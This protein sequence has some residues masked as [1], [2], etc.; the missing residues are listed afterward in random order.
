MERTQHNIGRK[1][2][3]P[4][5]EDFEAIIAQ[6]ESPLLR[7]A[8]RFVNDAA[9]AQD[10]VQEAFIRLYRTWHGGRLENGRL[11]GWL[12]RATH[13]A[14]VDLIRKEDRRRRLH[15]RHAEEPTLDPAARAADA[16]E[17]A[18]RRRIVLDHV[19]ALPPAEREVLVLRLQEGFSYRDSARVTCRTEGNVGCL[20]HQA[21]RRL[22][23]H[24]K[25][26]GVI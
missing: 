10:V 23:A 24:F 1:P 26:A 21:T 4:L 8:T 3:Q 13:N 6:F 18:D 12:Y 14:A 7:Y 11:S 22:A 19:A 16:N 9:S 2:V 15:A 25:K 17:I 20:L 5:R